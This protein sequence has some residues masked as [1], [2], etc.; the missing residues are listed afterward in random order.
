MKK[1]NYNHYS[2]IFTFQMLS[3]I[4]A[5]LSLIILPIPY[6]TYAFI[7]VLSFSLVFIIYKGAVPNYFYRDHN[8]KYKIIYKGNQMSFGK[9]Q[10]QNC[11]ASK[12]FWYE[13]ECPGVKE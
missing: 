7:L 5:G 10:C 13:T 3:Y 2:T 4:I 11:G 12:S 6:G 1:I 8:W 9:D